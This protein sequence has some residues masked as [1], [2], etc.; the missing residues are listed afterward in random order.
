MD[1]LSG[2]ESRFVLIRSATHSRVFGAGPRRPAGSFR[3]EI[4]GCFFFSAAMRA[5]YDEWKRYEFRN[6]TIV[7][8]LACTG[9]G[10]ERESS[11]IGERRL[12]HGRAPFGS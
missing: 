4:S 11:I 3:S 6:G 9:K 1:A 5:G 10:P 12:G 7:T 8:K 2:A